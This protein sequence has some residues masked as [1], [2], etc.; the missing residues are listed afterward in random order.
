MRDV[1]RK[2]PTGEWDYRKVDNQLVLSCQYEDRYA[3]VRFGKK[4]EIYDIG[5]EIAQFLRIPQ[6]V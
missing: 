4:D 2:Y 3:Q 5:D 6:K 1:K